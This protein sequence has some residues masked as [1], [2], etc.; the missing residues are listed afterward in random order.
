MCDEC[1]VPAWKSEDGFCLLK[2]KNN[3]MPDRDFEKNEM[4]TADLNFHYFN[5]T[6]DDGNLLQGY[7]AKLSTNDVTFETT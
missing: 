7:Y 4:F 5:M 1:I 6:K 2:V 3:W